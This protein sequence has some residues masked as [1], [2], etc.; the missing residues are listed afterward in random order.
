[1]VEETG[2]ATP[3][4]N[5]REPEYLTVTSGLPQ[6]RRVGMDAPWRWLRGG[7]R[8]FRA[9]TRTSLFYGVALTAMG[10]LLTQTW[11]KGAI[12]IAFLT[13]FLIVGPFLAM[14]LYDISRRVGDGRPVVVGDTMTAWKANRAAIGFYAVILALLLAVWVRV[15]VVVVALFFPAGVPSGAALAEQLLTSPDALAFIGAYVAAG[16][17]F[18]LFVFATS[19]VS[20]P[21]LLDREQMD[22]LSAMITSFNALRVNFAPMLLWGAIVVMLTGIGFAAFY[23]GLLVALPVIGHATWHAYKEV[24]E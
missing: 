23:V 16:C 10:V 3:E 17:G 22:T 18:A 11:G 2:N 20:L 12:E 21:M 7:W 19:V 9:A 5:R 24:V 8:D 13:G 14:G 6:I 1:M 4:G 15:S